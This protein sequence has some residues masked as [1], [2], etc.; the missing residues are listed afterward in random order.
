MI[1]KIISLILVALLVGGC[2]PIPAPRTVVLSPKMEGRI[3]ENGKPVSQRR[4]SVA[5]G[6]EARCED[7]MASAITDENGQF[8]IASVSR[9]DLFATI[10]LLPYHKV[11]AVEICLEDKAHA[12]HSLWS[13]GAYTLYQEGLGPLPREVNLECALPEGWTTF[14][15]QEQSRAGKYF[16]QSQTAGGACD[17]GGKAYP[18]EKGLSSDCPS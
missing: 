7:A 11:Y 18:M 3:T 17:P 16:C 13:T 1:D 8:S 4:V 9:R 14:D 2:V 12:M 5:V 6:A 15:F 10:S